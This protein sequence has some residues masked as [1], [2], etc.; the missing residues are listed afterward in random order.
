MATSFA[1]LESRVNSAVMAKLSN[2]QA[3]LNGVP[4]TGILSPGFQ[5]ASMD[6][7]GAA[8]SSP[9]FVLPAASVPAH[10]EGLLL[11]IASGQGAGTYR[12]GL[13]YPDGSGLVTLHLLLQTP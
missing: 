9:E 6:G 13:A 3:L 7:F 12:I 1:A 4:V 2:T 10:A 8:G 11:V 5:G